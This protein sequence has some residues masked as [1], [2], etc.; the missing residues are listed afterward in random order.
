LRLNLTDNQQAAVE[1][2]VGALAGG[3]T[4]FLFGREVVD[5]ARVAF[6]DAPDEFPPHLAIAVKAKPDDIDAEPNQALAALEDAAKAIGHRISDAANVAGAGVTTAAGAVTRPFRSV[7][8]DGDGIPD[9][10]QALTAVKGVSGAITGA[11]GA[12]G[13][14]GASLLKTRQ[15]G[16]HAASNDEHQIEDTSS[17]TDQ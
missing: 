12:V 8:L 5:A 17:D 13:R 3:V 4:R 9:A 16:R 10:P 15:R 2:G 7:D 14:A 1:Y 11:A 6:A